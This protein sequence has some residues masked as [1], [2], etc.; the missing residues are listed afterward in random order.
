MSIFYCEY[1]DKMEDGD[2][3]GCEAVFG[4]SKGVPAS[5]FCTEG[6]QA[7]Y[8]EPETIHGTLETRGEGRKKTANSNNKGN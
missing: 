2:F 3:V 6:H 4:G 1:H 5:M 8:P 7:L